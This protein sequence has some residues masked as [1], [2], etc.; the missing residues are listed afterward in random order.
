MR[1]DVASEIKSLKFAMHRVN[2]N[3]RKTLHD[4]GQADRHDRTSYPTHG[5]TYLPP[6][7][8]GMSM[9]GK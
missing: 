3:P 4:C 1:R 9:T 6:Y 2:P 8:Y 7:T 5:F